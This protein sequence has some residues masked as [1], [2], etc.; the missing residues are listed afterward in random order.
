MRSAALADLPS[1]NAAGEE[2]HGG[3]ISQGFAIAA[4]LQD[5]S[6]AAIKLGTGTRPDQPGRRLVRVNDATQPATQLSDWLGIVWLTPAMDRLFAGSPGDR[7]KFLDRLVMALNPGHA[8]QLSRYETALRERN[9]LLANDIPPDPAWLAALEL[10]MAEHGAALRLARRAT[11]QRLAQ[12][13]DGAAQ[14]PFAR[15]SL[16]Y[17]GEDA[18][19]ALLASFWL[20]TR[21]R[22]LAAG[23]TLSGPHRDDLEVHHAAHAIPAAQCSTGEQKALLIAILLAHV[24]AMQGERPLLLLLD[25]LAAHL[26]PLRRKALF[27]RLAGLDGQ[28]WLTGTE[29]APFAGLDGDH[30]HWEIS[31][32]TA[33]R[34]R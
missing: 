2:G 26:D 6:G 13:C 21:N 8:L 1:H 24:Q 16:H 7:R 4:L 19:A 3:E 30:A 9:R 29:M 5:R 17:S 15:P 33:A 27:D 32:G 25:E 12:I 14:G 20:A 34:V 31:N 23:R 28:Y 11:V 22:D 18:D 10:R